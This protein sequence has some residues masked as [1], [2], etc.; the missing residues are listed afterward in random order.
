MPK[1]L[2]IAEKP[3]LMREIQSVYE[4][5]KDEFDFEIDFAA[6][7]GHLVTLKLPD[8][9]DPSMKTYSW[10]TI[11]F[12]PTEHGGWQYKII[13]EKKSGNFQTAKERYDNLKDLINNQPYDFVIHAGDPDQEGELLI[14]LVLHQIG[15]KLPIKRFWTNDLTESHILDALHNMK[16]DRTDPS[17][18]NL[19]KAAYVRQHSDYLFGMNVSRAEE[20]KHLSRHVL[21]NARKRSKTLRPKLY[22]VF[23]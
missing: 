23:V 1:A 17:L 22:M 3:S 4:S 19:L 21:L 12:F 20:S 14:N 2:L 13:S 9:I 7:R 10:N 18:V 16:D 8:E 15:T 6:Q 11:P 5:H